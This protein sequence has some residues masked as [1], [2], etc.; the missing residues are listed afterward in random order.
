MNAPL[1]TPSRTISARFRDKG[2]HG[3]DTQ[4]AERGGHSRSSRQFRSHRGSRPVRDHFRHDRD[5]TS[6]ARISDEQVA[7]ITQAVAAQ[8][9]AERPRQRRRKWMLLIIGLVTG[10][11]V[12]IP[13]GIVVNLIS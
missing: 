3:R 6:P 5:A 8:A 2:L 7:A 12:S 10:A 4:S 11:L 13:I 1:D 9:E